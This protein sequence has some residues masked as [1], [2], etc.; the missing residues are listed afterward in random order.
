MSKQE[1][2]ALV[3]WAVETADK[4]N[5]GI[6]GV[7]NS[8]LSAKDELG[9]IDEAKKFVEKETAEMNRKVEDSE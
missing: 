4:Y 3:A 1:I 2:D 5:V 6:Q 7:I 8:V 9:D